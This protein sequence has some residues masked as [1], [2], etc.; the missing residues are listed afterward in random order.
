VAGSALLVRA[1][2]DGCG[3][4]TSGSAPVA[5]G[6]DPRPTAALRALLGAKHTPSRDPQP[7][8]QIGHRR[9]PCSAV[10]DYPL[11]TSLP[12]RPAT[13]SSS[14]STTTSSGATSPPATTD[15]P[16]STEAASYS[17]PSRSG[18]ANKVT[19]P[20]LRTRGGRFGV[21]DHRAVPRGMTA[22]GAS[23]RNDTETAH[24]GGSDLRIFVSSQVRSAL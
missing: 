12:T 21:Q 19:H 17:A 8:D 14:P 10:A 13:S 11:S 2:A 23:A 24:N 1:V 15:S 20:R 22:R 7:A 18:Y 4:G 6:C 16:S 9:R 3:S 5:R